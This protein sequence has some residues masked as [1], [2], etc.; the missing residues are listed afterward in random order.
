[1]LANPRA[2]EGKVFWVTG[3]WG[4]N[5]LRVYLPPELGADGV[6][7]WYPNGWWDTPYPIVSHVVVGN[8]ST[9]GPRTL[10]LGGYYSNV[11]PQVEF[12]ELQ[13]GP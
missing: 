12:I 11:E 2:S 1:M 5:P 9:G 13:P 6:M 7:A 3:T 4:D 8:S 10:V